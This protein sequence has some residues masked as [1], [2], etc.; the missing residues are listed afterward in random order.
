MAA[1][2]GAP[3]RSGRLVATVVGVLIAIA[4][5]A[6]M[7]WA[8]AGNSDPAVSSQEVSKDQSS[9]HEV[10]ISYQVKYGDGAVD[11]TCS[12]RAIATNGEE[13]G[14]ASFEPPRE[15]KPEQI[16]KVTFKTTRMA[17]SIEWLGCTAPGQKRPR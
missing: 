5:G 6:W 15:A 12:A 10:W 7:I 3:S 11:A 14:R 8:I 16:I 17:D 2:Y 13:V 1:R 9:A 4:L